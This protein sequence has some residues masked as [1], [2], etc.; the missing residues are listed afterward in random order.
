[1]KYRS[2]PHTVEAFQFQGT[3]A[4]AEE[5]KRWASA[6]DLEDCELSYQGE[7]EPVALDVITAGGLRTCEQGDYLYIQ[8]S[9]LYTEPALI[10]EDAYEPAD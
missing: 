10:F 9:A 8:Y 3:V 7:S 2:K 1:M 4:S 5:A 6:H